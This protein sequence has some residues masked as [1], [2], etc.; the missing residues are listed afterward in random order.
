[1]LAARLAK[2]DEAIA[3]VLTQEQGKPQDGFGSR[4]EMGGAQAWADLR[5]TCPCR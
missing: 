1:M 2:R 5:P 4:L 3:R